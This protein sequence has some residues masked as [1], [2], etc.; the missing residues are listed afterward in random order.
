M[1]TGFFSLHPLTALLF[2]TF[3]FVVVLAFSHPAILAL[4]FLFAFSLDFFYRKSDALKSLFKLYIPLFVFCGAF[5]SVFSHY[6]V[7]VLFTLKSGNAYT[8]EAILY[9]LAFGAKISSS[10]IWLNSFNEILTAEKIIFLFGRFSPRLALVLSMSLRFIPL[11]HR[12]YGE[13]AEARRGI[14]SVYE[15]KRLS[16]LRFAKD[17]ISILITW[18]LE[19][20]IDTADSM[21]ARGYGIGRRKAYSPYS[22]TKRDFSLTAFIVLSSALLIVFREALYASFNPVINIT[23]P[24]LIGALLLA[25][26]LSAGVYPLALNISEKRKWKLSL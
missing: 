21:N 20:G 9:G 8:L 14:G 19:R 1:K 23:P 11:F 18:I 10:L 15:S 3:Q 6:G 22:F 26:L 2:F 24:S 12:Q 17:N 25:V 7:T 16:K 13:I 5:N 4:N